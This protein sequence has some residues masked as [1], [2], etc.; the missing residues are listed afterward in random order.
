MQRFD[1][2]LIE[3]VQ[4]Q[5]CLYNTNLK[6]FKNS[7]LRSQAWN[8][9][10]NDLLKKGCECTTEEA[11]KRF[12]YLKKKFRDEKLR[13][14][15]VKSENSPLNSSFSHYNR[16]CFLWPYAEEERRASLDGTFAVERD[17]NDA[18]L[19]KE[20][21][22]LQ[23]DSPLSAALIEGVRK[24]VLLYDPNHT[25][26]KNAH[27][28][29]CAWDR[30]AEDLREMHASLDGE[31]CKRI[32]NALKRKFCAE[33]RKQIGSFSRGSPHKTSWTLYRNLEFLDPYMAHSETGLRHGAEE[34][35][36][37]ASPT[38]SP[39]AIARIESNSGGIK[40][41]M[42]EESHFTLKC[43]EERSEFTA[44][45]ETSEV[46]N[47]DFSR[48]I[49]GNN[50]CETHPKTMHLGGNPTV[51][52]VADPRVVTGIQ[53]ISSFTVHM[54]DNAVKTFLQGLLRFCSNS[55]EQH[56]QH[57][58]QFNERHPYTED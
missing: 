47:F 22:Q 12:S 37:E 20:D 9:I 53:A 43:D 52:T 57:T 54:D 58:S 19:R 6:T 36:T 16:M 39:S 11:R 32:W 15:G 55:L 56:L 30:I 13:Q 49:D 31:S 27:K 46:R 3:A 50:G 18:R 40:R 45:S 51:V 29:K 38:A 26:F 34:D 44:H 21:L 23:E 25:D 7:H 1:I 41:K 48:P 10:R 5:P 35:D 42:V 4:T 8:V 2:D 17:E 28:R 14:Q 24:N 33:K